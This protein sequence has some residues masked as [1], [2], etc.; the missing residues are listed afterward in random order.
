MHCYFSDLP[1]EQ[2]EESAEEQSDDETEAI[3]RPAI[4]D[5]ESIPDKDGK[6]IITP[7]NGCFLDFE[8]LVPGEVLLE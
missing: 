3:G 8:L 7:V 4:S 2:T 1:M 5:S 6:I